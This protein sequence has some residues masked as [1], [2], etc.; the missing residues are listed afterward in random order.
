MVRVEDVGI[1]RCQASGWISICPAL[2]SSLLQKYKS[3]S[4]FTRSMLQV[5][6]IHP[7]RSV[8][9][10]PWLPRRRSS[11]PKWRPPWR[12]CGLSLHSLPCHLSPRC[13]KTA[14]GNALRL[15]RYGLVGSA[16]LAQRMMQYGRFCTVESRLSQ[17]M[18]GK[19][20]SYQAWCP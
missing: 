13:N 6:G 20:W 10:L 15:D 9:N 14:W 11:T 4:L 17:A 3:F 2:L 12:K 1:V 8:N 19:R 16:C 18:G 7:S 5:Q